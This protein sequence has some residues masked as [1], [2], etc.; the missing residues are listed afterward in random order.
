MDQGLENGG[1]GRKTEDKQGQAR[2]WHA[3]AAEKDKKTKRQ[4][5]KTRYRNQ[6]ACVVVLCAFQW[7]FT[8]H[9]PYK[10]FDHFNHSW[11]V[12]LQL[13]I[14][15]HVKFIAQLQTLEWEPQAN[16]ALSQK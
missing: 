11:V 4:K 5:K 6:G 10:L 16:V 8:I 7:Y 14:P 9:T 2:S 13:E 1:Q 12:L 15:F 3:M